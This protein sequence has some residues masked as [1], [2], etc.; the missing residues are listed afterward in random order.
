MHL[1]FDNNI[2]WRL[3]KSDAALRNWNESLVK[4]DLIPASGMLGTVPTPFMLLE[5]LG[6][7]PGTPNIPLPREYCQEPLDSEA[8]KK[9]LFQKAQVHY[10]AMP[11]LQVN[12]IRNCVN[13]QRNRTTQNGRQ[14]FDKIFA[15]VIAR[16]GFE[17]Q[18][19]DCLALNFVYG[20]PVPQGAKEAFRS[21]LE[22]DIF[23]SLGEQRN[24]NQTRVIELAWEWW[25]PHL[26]KHN[27]IQPEIA[28]RIA[29]SIELK[30]AGDLGDTEIVHYATLGRWDS[31]SLHPVVAFTSDPPQKIKDRLFVFKAA[32][33]LTYDRI[34][35][36]TDLARRPFPLIEPVSGKV[37]LCDD[38]GYVIEM[39]DVST[40]EGV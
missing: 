17:V 5:S 34:K 10:R 38:A 30:R 9:Y 25:V 32:V 12:A 3:C 18:I 6:I 29:R 20:Y 19:H 24:I 36:Y 1:I 39:I 37:G 26:A 22:I 15:E 11:T 27:A 40:L 7:K 33:R 21:S 2:F 13:Y 8:I 14:L 28:E 23:R 31:G 35:D 4:F 16:D